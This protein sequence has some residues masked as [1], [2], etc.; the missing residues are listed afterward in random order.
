MR[1][2]KY[3]I[4]VISVISAPSFAS[5]FQHNLEVGS[6][7]SSD[8]FGDG[9]LNVDY[10]YYFTPVSNSKDLPK[11][12]IEEY[13]N[14]NFIYTNYSTYSDRASYSLG[15]R[16]YATNDWFVQGDYS[17][18]SYDN[19]DNDSDGFE[20]ITGYHFNKFSLLKFNYKESE[21]DHRS[22]E[23]IVTDLGISYSQ[24]IP[25][26]STSGVNFSASYNKS[27]YEIKWSERNKKSDNDLIRVNFD[28]FINNSWSIGASHINADSSYNTI[29]T[30]YW[31]QFTKHLSLSAGAETSI[32]GSNGTSIYLKGT[33]RF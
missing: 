13:S 22:S 2:L 25:L 18:N 32:D 1:K 12:L 5:E 15:A 20:F 28:W 21:L 26:N 3:L 6:L 33:Y 14:A 29:N 19:N 16:Y 24:F 7:S 23:Y 10:T 4:S 8:D 11:R 27:K 30:Q 9:L 17:A 31:H